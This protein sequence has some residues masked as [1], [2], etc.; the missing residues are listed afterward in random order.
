MAH[1]A[2]ER[3][4]AIVAS[5][6]EGRVCK[7]IPESLCDEQPSNFF[8]HVFSLTATKTG[9][10]LMDPKLVLAWL[11]EALGAPAWQIGLL[12]PVRESGS[13]LPQLVLAARIRAKEIRKRVWAAASLGQGLAV[14]GM[15]ASGYVFTGGTAGG[16]V[17]AFL[18]LFALSRSAASVSYKDV[19]GKTVSKATRGR[20]TG[21]AGSVASANVLVFGALVSTGVLPLTVETILWAL[22]VAGA[23]WFVAASVFMTLAE[24]PGATRGGGKPLQVAREQLGI[25]RTETQLRR[26]IAVRGLLIPTALAPPYVLAVAGASG[27]ERVGA[28]GPFVIASAAATVSSG[29]I[30]GRLAD[31]SSRKTL[32][33]AA[34]MAAAVLAGTA[35]LSATVPGYTNRS[36]VLPTGLFILMVAYQGVRVGRSTHIVDMVG[37]EKRAAYVA[38][39]NTAIGILLVGGSAFGALAQ[40][41]G[42]WVVLATFAALCALAAVGALTLEEVQQD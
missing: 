33:L 42:A 7:D 12:V 14:L 28:L 16:A 11:L 8:R 29:W 30:W 26:F 6:D 23:L 17:I 40:L 13:L 34:A 20:A 18:T 15:A 5:D 31:R 38:I 19:L 22:V 21:T 35:L 24:R 9:D 3:A 36:W 25:L 41:A 1:P 32:V 2:T 4:Y 39:S 27:P 10:G 37:E